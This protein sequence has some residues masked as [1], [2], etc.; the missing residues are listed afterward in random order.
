M[1]YAVV[2]LSDGSIVRSG[3]C[4]NPSDLAFQSEGAGQIAVDVSSFTDWTMDERHYYYNGN[5]VQQRA[6]LSYTANTTVLVN[7]NAVIT[8]PANTTVTIDG[9]LVGT[10]DGS[11]FETLVFTDAGTYAITLKFWPYLDAN[12]GITAS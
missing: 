7:A 1:I 5:A 6:T 12:F 4:S 2:N 9:T 8:A 11:G 10:I 3:M